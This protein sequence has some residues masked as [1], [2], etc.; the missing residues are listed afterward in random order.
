MLTQRLLLISANRLP[1]SLSLS[2]S[3]F[4]HYSPLLQKCKN[5]CS[6][7]ITGFS[8]IFHTLSPWRSP[9]SDLRSTLSSRRS[10]RD[11][12]LGA[13]CHLSIYTLAQCH[14]TPSP[15]S[16]TR[17]KPPRNLKMSACLSC[18]GVATEPG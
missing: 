12:S 8:H 14:G 6:V 7:L 1:L 18:H 13:W 11:T 5:G 3:P 10:P 2:F 16:E 9:V 4:I 15:N 17:E